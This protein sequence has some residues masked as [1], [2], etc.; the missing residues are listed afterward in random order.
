MHLLL[1]FG[2]NP[3]VA[4]HGG[5]TALHSAA[6]RDYPSLAA[7]LPAAGADP[8]ARSDDGR[9]ALEMARSENRSRALAALEH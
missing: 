6:H 7:L 5:W 9:S 2:A 4:Q 8:E 1:A 3:N